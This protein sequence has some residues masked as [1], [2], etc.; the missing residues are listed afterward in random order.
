MN[1]AI[2]MS[3]GHHDRNILN[4]CF[5]YLDPNCVLESFER[6]DWILKENRKVMSAVVGLFIGFVLH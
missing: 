5:R 2:P 1:F 6:V 4:P 3:S